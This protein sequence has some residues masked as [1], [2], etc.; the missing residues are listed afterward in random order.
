MFVAING[1]VVCEPRLSAARRTESSFGSDGGSRLSSARGAESSFDRFQNWRNEVEGSA[2]SR[3]AAFGSS[4][5]LR[6]VES[7]LRPSWLPVQDVQFRWSLARW[8]RNV[9]MSR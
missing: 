5:S 8:M 1:Y 9:E 6:V 7:R 2:G 3:E 4:T